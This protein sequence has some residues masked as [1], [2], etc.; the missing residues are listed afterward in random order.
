MRSRSDFSSVRMFVKFIMAPSAAHI[1]TGE[2]ESSNTRTKK[3][4]VTNR[5]PRPRRVWG[6]KT[7]LLTNFLIVAIGARRCEFQHLASAVKYRH[8]I[9]STAYCSFAY[10]LACFR[11]GCRGRRL[12]RD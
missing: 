5:Y 1:L 7:R 12:S 9:K 2:Q 11:M 10:A 6:V 8:S 4:E 3:G